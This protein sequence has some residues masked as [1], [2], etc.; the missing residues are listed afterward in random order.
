MANLSARQVFTNP[1][2]FL[3]FGF[4]AGLSPKAPGTMGTVAAIP[5]YLLLAWSGPVAYYSF[6]AV[7]LVAGAFICGYTARRLGVD[8]PSPVVW[9]EVVGYLITMAAVP[10]G[11]LWILAGFLLFRLFDIWKPWPIR[12]LDRSV[13][14]GLGIM[15]DDV[16]AG[17]FSCVLL[18][19]SLY[20][21]KL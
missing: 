10:L 6:L 5:I 13:K 2:H 21:L 8:D 12:W 20:L 18:N 15:L 1:I 19:L 4:G 11:F 14:G 9:D 7:A 16:V 17:L 3:A